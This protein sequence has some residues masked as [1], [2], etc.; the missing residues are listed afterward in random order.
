MIY[1][2]NIIEDDVTVLVPVT[3]EF[4][5]RHVPYALDTSSTETLQWGSLIFASDPVRVGMYWEVTIQASS[6]EGMPS[7]EYVYNL[8]TPNGV[9]MESGVLM[10]GLDGAEPSE[11]EQEQYYI[12]P[13]YGEE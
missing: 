11:Y 8:V 4:S 5:R 3:K 1:L 12:T 10:K 6:M 13:E 7:G 2:P 9:V